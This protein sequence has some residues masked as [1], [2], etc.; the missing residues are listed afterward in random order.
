MATCPLEMLG[1]KFDL[2]R[3]DRHVRAYIRPPRVK[4]LGRSAR[5]VFAPLGPRVADKILFRASHSLISRETPVRPEQKEC[6]GQSCSCFHIRHICLQP[7]GSVVQRRRRKDCMSDGVGR[8][9][10]R[11]RC[12]PLHVRKTG[13]FERRSTGCGAVVLLA[14]LDPRPVC[15]MQ[16]RLALACSVLMSHP[17]RTFI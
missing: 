1:V 11:W 10:Q 6:D 13:C 16:E 4:H 2:A 17:R 8:R 14:L 9:R 12:H 3:S 7:S 15:A 5:A